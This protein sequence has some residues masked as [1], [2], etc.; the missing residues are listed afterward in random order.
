MSGPEIDKHFKDQFEGQVEPIMESDWENFEAMAFES[1]SGWHK[2]KWALGLLLLFSLAGAVY[3]GSLEKNQNDE[4][5]TNSKVESTSVSESEN[6]ISID[7]DKD[8]LNTSIVQSKTDEL[9]SEPKTQTENNDATEPLN[10]G[11]EP[12]KND[13]VSTKSDETASQSSSF[14]S[15]HG[16]TL[17]AQD[18]SALIAS[19]TASKSRK[20]DEAIKSADAMS[21]EK[22]A[23][24]EDKL[25]SPV[26]PEVF[27]IDEEYGQIE[28]M[29]LSEI[30]RDTE[31]KF[32]S[33]ENEISGPDVDGSSLEI[34]G[35]YEWN[36]SIGQIA[37]VG[38]MYQISKSKWTYG[39]GL[40]V[41][42]SS[43]I[44]WNQNREDL[45]YGFDSDQRSYT[46]NTKSFTYLTVPVSIARQFGGVHQVYAGAEFGF[47]VHAS[48]SYTENES[49]G[50]KSEGY[51]YNFGNPDFLFFLNAGYNYQLG[52]NW[53][54]GPGVNISPQNWSETNDSPLGGY[55]KLTYLLK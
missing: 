13:E 49:N 52:T 29:D 33:A 36:R 31:A 35:Q 9:G 4:L 53:K 20:T 46:L 6:E 48:Q 11:E 16:S 22:S 44:S 5:L 28:S 10:S 1:K 30:D 50:Q 41:A 3:Y 43:G 39:A 40:A 18:E 27:V 14:A 23:F 21:N 54:L 8:Q 17:P 55:F 45:V 15:S 2:G 51:L 24:K 7:S 47:V 19:G 32:S 42:Y 34:F 12:V 37:K 38:G 26:E 25:L